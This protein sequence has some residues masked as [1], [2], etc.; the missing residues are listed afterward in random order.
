MFI[1]DPLGSPCLLGIP[2]DPHVYWESPGIPKS[3]GIPHILR[4]QSFCESPGI[5]KSLGI[6]H[7]LRFQS[8]WGSRSFLGIPVFI[9]DPRVYW[10][11]PCLL[12]IPWDP[13]VYWGS[14]G[15]PM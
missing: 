1:G 14:P 10:G 3:F 4:F 9:G 5:P 13:H 7:I 12:G 15:I 11:S 6:P 8:F 2:W